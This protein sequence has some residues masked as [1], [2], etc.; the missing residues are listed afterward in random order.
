MRTVSRSS[1]A[2]SSMPSEARCSAPSSG[3][4]AIFRERISGAKDGLHSDPAKNE[5]AAAEA[6][7]ERDI[8]FLKE[9]E[10]DAK[11]ARRESQRIQSERQGRADAARR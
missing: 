3:S 2:R 10:R 8:E 11:D 5:L 7:A 4:R 1:G 9:S 6:S